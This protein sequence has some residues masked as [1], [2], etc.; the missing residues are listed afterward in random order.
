[1]GQAMIRNRGGA[2]TG[3]PKYEYTGKSTL[4]DDGNKNWQLKFLE[5]GTFKI[6]DYSK[7]NVDVFLVGG[8]GAGN[9]KGGAGGGGYSATKTNIELLKGVAYSINIGNGG[10]ATGAAGTQ[11]T[12][13][14]YTSNGGG[15][16]VAGVITGQ[17]CDVQGTTGSAGNVYS[18]SSLSASAVSMGNGIKTVN[19]AYPITSATHT[20]GTS[21]YKGVTG[22][23][24]CTIVLYGAYI[25]TNGSNGTGGG[26]VYAFGGS[27]GIQYGGTG[28]APGTASGGPNTGKGGDGSNNYN[29]TA[30]GSGG[31]GFVII[32]NKR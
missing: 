22:Y 9:K 24:R 29:G 4:I 17:T 23:Y 16:G 3:P 15:G 26:L 19:L 31:K 7:L 2:P 13:F 25:T 11:T 20:N 18:Y 27:S 6:K 32:R 12:A 1:M 5:S 28:K 14:G 30:F 10:T 8:G 21:L